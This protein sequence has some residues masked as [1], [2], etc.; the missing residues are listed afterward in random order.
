MT[1]DGFRLRPRG[2][3]DLA[4]AAAFGFGPRAAAG[5]DGPRRMAL[6]FCVDGETALAGVALR[7]SDDGAVL[8][9]VQGDADPRAVRRQVARVLS[10]DHDGEAWAAVADAD[11]VLRDLR[12]RRPGMRP[13]LFHSPYEAAAWAVISAR[14]PAAQAARTRDAIAAALG[15]AFDLDGERLTAFPTPARL[16]EVRPGPGLPEVKVERLHALADATLAGELDQPAL[17][18]M[19]P[20]DAEAHVQRLPG[21]GPFY[22]TLIVVRA[23]GHADAL[24]R[25]EPI[26]QAAVGRFYG[27]DGPATAAQ[28]EK[29]AEAWRPFRTWAT[30]LLHAAGQEA[31]IT[32]RSARRSA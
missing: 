16:R 6:A 5:R 3:F 1:P 29:L 22:A 21:I 17:L 13:V 30:V 11:P 4:E 2:A 28:L 8:G 9:E 14:R 10:L 27:L 24:V 26:T 15:A 18:A 12:A 19:A 23:T 32:A 25:G 20:A 7:Q 31:G